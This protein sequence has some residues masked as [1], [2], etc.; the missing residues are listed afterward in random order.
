MESNL[1]YNQ[2]SKKEFHGETLIQ[3]KRDRDDEDTTE[4]EDSDFEDRKRHRHR[5]MRKARPSSANTDANRTQYVPEPAVGATLG[6]VTGGLTGWGLQPYIT[7]FLPEDDQKKLIARVL[8]AGSMGAL[9]TGFG[10][11]GSYLQKDGSNAQAAKAGAI[12]GAGLGAVGGASLGVVPYFYPQDAGRVIGEDLERMR[13]VKQAALVSTLGT[14][15]GAGIGAGLGATVMTAINNTKPGSGKVNM[16]FSLNPSK[17]K[18]A[19]KK[20]K[21]R[22]IIIDS[23]D[24]ER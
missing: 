17:R 5:K 21:P 6:F 3:M 16:R 15:A 10:A 4:D 19:Q 2:W 18:H 1:H 14:I 12:L 9:G 8:I 13:S 7:H 22:V 20:K 24:D 11:L 23:S